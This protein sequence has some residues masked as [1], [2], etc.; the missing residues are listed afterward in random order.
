MGALREVESPN[1][2]ISIASLGK[3]VIGGRGDYTL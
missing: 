1:W 3:V 2:T